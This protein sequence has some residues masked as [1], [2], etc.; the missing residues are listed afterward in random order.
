MPVLPTHTTLSSQLRQPRIQRTSQI[1]Q[2]PPPI[3]PTLQY[4]R[5]R[6]LTLRRKSHPMDPLP[7]MRFLELVIVPLVRPALTTGLTQIPDRRRP[8]FKRNAGLIARLIQGLDIH[9]SVDLD[10]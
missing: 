7:R 3:L 2:P 1:R 9:R 8:M 6:T 10:R 4:C 5:E